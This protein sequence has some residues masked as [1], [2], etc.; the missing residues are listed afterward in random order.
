MKVV[1]IIFN[2]YVSQDQPHKIL[3]CYTNNTEE[4]PYIFSNDMNVDNDRFI[5]IYRTVINQYFKQSH[6]LQRYIIAT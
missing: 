4:I 1:N 5:F 6:G 2:V 3:C